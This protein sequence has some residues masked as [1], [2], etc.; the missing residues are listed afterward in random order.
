MGKLKPPPAPRDANDMPKIVN[1]RLLAEART[2]TNEP[3]NAPKLLQRRT[4]NL[5]RENPFARLL[6]FVLRFSM[7]S[8]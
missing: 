1:P 2:F 6:A 4:R 7:C 5:T 3:P 8:L